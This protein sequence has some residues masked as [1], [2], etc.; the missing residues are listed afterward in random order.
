MSRSDAV[1]GVL[2]AVLG[3]YAGLKAY[4][5]GLGEFRE[6]GAGFFPFIGAMLVAGCSVAIVIRAF[7]HG[8]DRGVSQEVGELA[9][10][11]WAKIGLCVAAL[12]LYPAV[13]PFIGF[14]AST[15]LFMLAL[16]RFDASTTWR[17]AFAIASLGTLAFWLLFVHVLGVQFPRSVLGI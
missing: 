11:G 8:R 4:S 17:G 10:K 1:S 15:L 13:L 12:L 2:L 14:S 9:P 5:F 16:S 7:A 3:A 6:P